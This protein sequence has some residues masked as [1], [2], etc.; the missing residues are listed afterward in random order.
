[1]DE[2]S[3]GA[4]TKAID[5]L[6]HAFIGYGTGGNSP[7]AIV[8]AYFDWASH[9]VMV[10]GKQME[11]QKNLFRNLSRFAVYSGRVMRNENPEPPMTPLPQDYRFKNEAWQRFPFNLLHQSFLMQEQWWHYATTGVPGVAKRNEEM[12]SFGAR[13]ILDMFSPSNFPLTNPEVLAKTMKTGGRNFIDGFKNWSQDLQRQINKEPPAGSEK[14]QVG[15]NLAVTPGKVIFRNHLIELIQY[16]PT[17]EKVQKEPLLIVPAWIMKYYI[18]DLS[19]Q[20]SMVKYLVDQGHTVFMISWLNP[21][22]QDRNLS[23]D[24]YR[25]HGVM[26]AIDAVSHIVPDTPIHT[27][28]YCLGGTILSIAAATMARDNDNRIASVTL[29]AAQTDFTEA[30]ELMLFINES[31]LTFLE[32][33]MW[34]QGYL[35]S[36]QMAGAFMMLRSK[37]LLYS[38]IVH[39]YMMGERNGMNDLMSWNADTTRMPY[40]MHSQYLRSLFLNNDL[41][42]GRFEVGA[43]PI[44]LRDIR[45]PIFA[46]GASKDHVAPWQSVFKIRRLTSA[47]EVTFLLT[48]GGHNAGII[49]E[50]GHARRS[51]MVNTRKRGDKYVGPDAWLEVA[52]KHEGSWWPHWHEWLRNHS[53]GETT[54]PAMGNVEAGY[55]EICDAPGTYILQK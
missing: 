44:F 43:N 52:E 26:A 20:N 7:A 46:V 15:K 14:Y 21:T 31:Q 38:R 33:L 50:P 18:L 9:L 28:G 8:Q 24:D 55:H 4:E 32:D 35:D 11:L 13:Q 22:S 48:S 54:A 39:E 30:G 6:I 45:V 3:I 5:R 1:M 53:S 12:V 36:E 42:E 37:D 49:S 17:T 25:K 10:P 34:E 41:A 23:M 51:Y 47:P 16:T 2:R 40:R 27:A 19:E 29:F